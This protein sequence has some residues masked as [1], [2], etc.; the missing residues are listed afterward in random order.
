MVCNNCSK[1]ITDNSTSCP[2]CG[3]IV[4]KELI[5]NILIDTTTN[6]NSLLSAITCTQCGSPDVEIISPELVFCKNCHTRLMIN[7]RKSKIE[8][9]NTVHIHINDNSYNPE[10]V[11]FYV[12]PKGVDTVTFFV[13]ALT[14]LALNKNTPVDI[15][16]N[17]TF[18][19]IETEYRQ[20]LVA[21]GLAELNYSASIGYDYEVTYT[22]YRNGKIY[23]NTRIET[24]WES[25]S[26]NHTGNYTVA[27][28]N[29]EDCKNSN[30]DD[31][32]NC[33]SSNF[34]NKYENEKTESSA[35]LLP[36]EITIA[37]AQ[38]KIKETASNHCKN[39]LPG[40]QHAQFTCNGKVNISK[41]ESHVVPQYK[42]AYKY[43]N[44]SAKELYMHA[45]KGSQMRGE[46]INTSL[47]TKKAIN[48]VA[49]EKFKYFT[50]I[51]FFMLLITIAL[52][53][54]KATYV[55]GVILTTVSLLV[56]IYAM[57]IYSIIC[58]KLHEKYN[59]LKRQSLVN[60]LKDRNLTIPEKL[61]SLEETNS[62]KK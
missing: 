39:N 2:H 49:E 13:N 10:P 57:V 50:Y 54:I 62:S 46:I 11:T 24:K 55:I 35:P 12:M 18:L 33:L 25:L 43:N 6:N 27:V 3:A 53:L 47:E 52:S 37:N 15:I 22:E 8:S 29:E 17:T 21:T 36:T 45:I 40:N 28:S 9:N 4:D 41:L 16:E 42:F 1:N 19:P 7:Q 44:Q 20:Y 59:D 31:Y 30:P 32:I 60:F 56:N 23:E 5:P 14:E 34:A 51:N 38:Q 48:D 58:T 26:G 61:K